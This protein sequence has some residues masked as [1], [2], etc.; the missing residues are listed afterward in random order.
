MSSLSGNSIWVV[1]APRVTVD[2]M[3]STSGRPAMAV[4]IGRVI[5]V[6]ISEGAAPFSVMV[7]TTLGKVTFGR[8]LIGSFMYEAE[9]R[10]TRAMNRMATGTGFWIPQVEMRSWAI[11]RP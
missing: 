3:V 11:R 7:I 4:S 9:P 6:S 8:C 5:W 2:W 1:D 10:A